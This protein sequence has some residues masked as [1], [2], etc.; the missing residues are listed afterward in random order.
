MSQFKMG[1]NIMKTSAIPFRKL[2]ITA[3]SFCLL[4][5]AAMLPTA[6]AQAQTCCGCGAVT[7]MHV[8][9]RNTVK[10]NIENQ[11]ELHKN[12]LKNTW[13]EQLL[14]PQLQLY[15]QQDTQ[16][17]I[18]AQ[19]IRSTFADARNTNAYARTV[20]RQS[21]EMTMELMPDETTAQVACGVSDLPAAQQAAA[22]TT[23]QI[24]DSSAARRLGRSAGTSGI[25]IA[26][27]MRDRFDI[28]KRYFCNPEGWGGVLS[29]VCKDAG[30]APDL[31]IQ[32][33]AV[34]ADKKPIGIGNR[35][36]LDLDDNPADRSTTDE[37]IVE[38]FRTNLFGNQ[39]AAR[40]T[41][42]QFAQTNTQLAY[43]NQRGLEAKRNVA[44]YSFNSYIGEKKKSE[45][46]KGS[47]E[48]LENTLKNLNLG[49][50]DEILERAGE[51]PSY[52]AI[53]EVL[54]K[55]AY[56]SP[57]FYTNLTNLSPQVAQTHASVQAVGLMQ[58]RDVYESLLRSE[59]I[60]SLIVEMELAD[61]QRE[62]QAT[63][64]R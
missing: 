61:R 28:F 48:F 26:S 25:A 21:A 60:L 24:S 9:T 34:D 47:K 14:K 52:Y 53:M 23:T 55:K 46:G 45:G 17:E 50:A 30:E 27:D 36:T 49:N 41:R 62:V 32:F 1:K 58:M 15:S 39:L 10:M 56:Q 8:L 33:S 54:G 29:N 19:N 37:V 13:W 12:Y 35:W 51:N 18:Q 7:G 6:P 20:Q 5:G 3:A 40:P 11:Y 22:A 64:L 38:A 42:D 44:E 4:I 63:T 2:G 59:M 16:T 57:D 31:D 43:L